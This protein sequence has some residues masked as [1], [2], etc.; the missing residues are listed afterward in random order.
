MAPVATGGPE[1]L[2]TPVNGVST[3]W[4]STSSCSSSPG[5]TS[6]TAA[7]NTTDR[8]TALPPTAIAVRPSFWNCPSPVGRSGG[9]GMDVLKSAAVS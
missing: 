5:F 4:T 9:A 6:V 3:G 2:T 8:P 1:A 7:L